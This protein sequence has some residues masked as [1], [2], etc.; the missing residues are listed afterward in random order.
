MKVF[1]TGGS[2]Y[3]GQATIA[4]LRRGGHEVA[5]LVRSEHGAEAV[6]ALGATPVMG[7]LGHTSTPAVPGSTGTPRSW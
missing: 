5:A 3:I 7:T 1:V 4:A 2:G 6:A